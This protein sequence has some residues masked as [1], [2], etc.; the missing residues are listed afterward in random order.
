MPY[1][2]I[3]ALSREKLLIS[4]DSRW[5]VLRQTRSDL[6]PALALQ[7]ELLTLR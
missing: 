3:Q 6:E 7:R 1:V 4:A 2:T 5:Q